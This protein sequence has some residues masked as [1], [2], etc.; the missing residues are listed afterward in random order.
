MPALRIE[1]PRAFA[2]LLQP[3]RYKGAWGGRGSAKSWFFADA[4]LER[5]VLEP[6]TRFVCIRE[7]QRSL[8]QSVK[9]LLE[10]RI[11]AHGL[12]SLFRVLNTHIEAGR[13][14]RIAFIGMQNHTAESVKSLEG[15]D[16]AWVEEAQSLSQRSLDLLRPTIRKDGSE[17]WFSWNP[18]HASDPV[19]RFLRVNPP[20]GAIVVK[21]NYRDN[22]WLPAELRREADWCRERDPEKYA[23]I[24]RG[25]YERQSEARVFKN[26]TSREFET[27]EGVTLYY[28]ADWG[29]S[30]D[31]T[32]LVRCWIDGRTLYIDREAYKV[33]CEIDHM[34]ALFDQLDGGRCRSWPITADSARPESISYMQR[35]GFPRMVRSKKG[36]NSVAEGVAFLQNF[37]IVIHP[38]C[39]HACDEF[40]LYAYK[41]DKLT[42]N[43]I[44]VLEDTKNHVID[45]VRYAIEAVRHGPSVAAILPQKGVRW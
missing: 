3:A 16:G 13:D 1:T 30:V 18:R 26:W 25:E 14:G 22:P 43:V 44:P 8:D 34:P 4:L 7:I 42:G 23:H 41:T 21:A 24:W 20:P 35:H 37:D 10:D 33:G 17:L 11:Q 9:R 31:P 45:A 19:D 5:F 2:P 32:V 28:G 12:G 39:V 29:F 40:T 27:P 36:A 6:N 15:Y 38:R